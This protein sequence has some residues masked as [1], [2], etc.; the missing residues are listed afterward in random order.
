M[1][2]FLASATIAALAA[3]GYVWALGAFTRL[4]VS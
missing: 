2:R 1:R 4:V 3:A